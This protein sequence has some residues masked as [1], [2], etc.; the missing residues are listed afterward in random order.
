MAV[1]TCSLCNTELLDNLIC[2]AGRCNKFYHYTCVGFSRTIFDGYKKVN[3]LRWQCTNC[4]D[5]FNGICTKLDNLTYLV[6]EMKTMINLCGLVKSAVDSA[7]QEFV[8]T[9]NS[10]KATNTIDDTPI[11]NNKKSKKKK[12]R[13]QNKHVRNIESSSPLNGNVIHETP[14][15]LNTSTVSL[16]SHTDVSSDQLESTVIE[17]DTRANSNSQQSNVH[18]H[19]INHGIRI[20]DKRKYL[21]LSGFH[22]ST[23]AHQV[24]SMVSS[25]LAVNK[26]E[27]ICR[28]LKSSRRNYDDFHHISFRV[29]LKNTD[30]KDALHP[31]KWPEGITCK[32]FNP[33][34]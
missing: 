13:K 14:V 27:I 8:P 7:L 15:S 21:W 29:G 34:N 25:I 26:S 2:C 17:A 24:V 18:D 28:S 22:Y 31:N 19:N 33:K 4:I 11:P 6:N 30:I 9:I 23:T 1:S 10:K 16:S 12:K 20:A 32:I 3:G 5:E